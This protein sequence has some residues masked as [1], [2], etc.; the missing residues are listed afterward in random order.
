MEELEGLEYD[1]LVL[2]QNVHK[3]TGKLTKLQGNMSAEVSIDAG[4]T[5]LVTGLGYLREDTPDTLIQESLGDTI[6]ISKTKLLE[7]IKSKSK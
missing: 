1:E 3:I 2:D 4:A 7:F 5:W 6:I